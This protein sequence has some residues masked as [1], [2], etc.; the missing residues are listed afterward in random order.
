MRFYFP[1]GGKKT[2]KG[3]ALGIIENMM[4]SNPERVT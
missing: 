4:K 2:A 3:N 1:E